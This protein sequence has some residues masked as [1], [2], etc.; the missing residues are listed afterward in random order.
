M[1]VFSERERTV[2][3]WLDKHQ[4]TTTIAIKDFLEVLFFNQAIATI[5][6][7]KSQI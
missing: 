6:N 7:L 5:F 2:I 4:T 3:E 1:K